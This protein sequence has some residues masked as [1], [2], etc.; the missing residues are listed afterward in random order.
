HVQMILGID[1]NKYSVDVTRGMLDAHR[2]KWRARGVDFPAMVMLVVPRLGYVKVARADLDQRSILMTLS[3]MHREGIPLS[4][5]VNA[6][7][8]AYPDFRPIG[9]MDKMQEK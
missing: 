5:I 8:A 9:W 6:A 7:K 3:N 4:D 2:A 1:M